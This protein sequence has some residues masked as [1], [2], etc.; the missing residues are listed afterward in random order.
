MMLMVISI[1]VAAFVVLSS[2]KDGFSTEFPNGILNMDEKYNCSFMEFMSLMT[3]CTVV[4]ACVMIW[5]QRNFS[6]PEIHNGGSERTWT[7]KENEVI[8]ENRLQSLK[9]KSNRIL[10]LEHRL[11]LL[12]VQHE[13]QAEYELQSE[14][15]RTLSLGANHLR[16]LALEDKFNEILALK[17]RDYR[18]SA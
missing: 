2:Q 10:A 7:I 15:G 11:N 16:I 4:A 1:V 6:A 18:S 5:P 3:I 13:L 9:A 17:T 8:F 12:Q 14:F